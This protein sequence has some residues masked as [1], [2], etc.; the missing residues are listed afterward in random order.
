ML[1]YP[2]YYVFVP[3]MNLSADMFQ[4]FYNPD[5]RTC[6]VQDHAM[7]TKIY[8]DA[9]SPFG[10]DT[11]DRR[12]VE[13]NNIKWAD[14]KLKVARQFVDRDTGELETWLTWAP[15]LCAVIGLGMS[16]LHALYDF[17]EHRRDTRVHVS[18]RFVVF[19]VSSQA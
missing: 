14:T 7:L 18:F 12:N 3:R 11:S 4:A 6:P 17:Y 15:W 16:V 2:S 19:L 13:S 8:Q 5:G 9:K 1:M 10:M